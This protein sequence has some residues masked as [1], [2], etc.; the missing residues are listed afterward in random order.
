[1]PRVGKIEV[2]HEE[3]KL[4]IPRVGQIEVGLYIQRSVVNINKVIVKVKFFECMGSYST[5]TFECDLS[6]IKLLY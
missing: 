2:G 3:P 4:E 5:L 1:M 6:R